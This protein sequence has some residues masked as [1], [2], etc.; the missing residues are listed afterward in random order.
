MGAPKGRP[1]PAGSGGSRKGIPNAV[2]AEVRAMIEGA[3]V[4]GGG[5][6]YFEAQMHENPA[7][8]MALVGKILPKE[9]KAEH[10]GEVGITLIERIIIRPKRDETANG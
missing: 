4:A 3:L 5:Q 7:A 9:I 6:K 8:F 10:R 1:K 2:T